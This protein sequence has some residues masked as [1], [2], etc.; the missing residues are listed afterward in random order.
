MAPATGNTKPYKAWAAH[1][2]TGHPDLALTHHQQ[3]LQ[4]ATDLSQPT[5]QARAHD[6]LAHAHHALNHHDQARRHWQHA[7]NILTSLGTDHTE[8]I[9]ASIPS[10]RA[11][12][13][14]LDQQPPT[15]LEMSRRARSLVAQRHPYGSSRLSEANH[16][17]ARAA[18]RTVKK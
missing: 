8:D 13:T 3:A 18:A 16:A 12:L 17:S 11:H 7:L 4:L 2:A 5:D 15:C 6:G 9:E 1:H 14:K 10:I